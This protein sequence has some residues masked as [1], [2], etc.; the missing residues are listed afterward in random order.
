M[1]EYTPWK[2]LGLSELDYYK[3][4]YLEARRDAFEYQCLAESWMSSYDELKDKYEPL[5]L[6]TS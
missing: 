4:L 6:T 5:E 2:S 1:N 3:Q